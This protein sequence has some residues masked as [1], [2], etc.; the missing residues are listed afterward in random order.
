MLRSMKKT[1]F[2]FFGTLNFVPKHISRCQNASLVDSILTIWVKVNIFFFACIC[3]MLFM[4]L[5]LASN[6][7]F[8]TPN[9]K[10]VVFLV[11]RLSEHVEYRDL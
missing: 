7:I 11:K 10:M 4:R 9:I 8:F 5:D 2:R 6:F 1:F 3:A